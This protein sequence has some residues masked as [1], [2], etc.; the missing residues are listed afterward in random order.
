MNI[1]KIENPPL[2]LAFPLVLPAVSTSLDPQL[3]VFVCFGTVTVD[4]SHNICSEPF[5]I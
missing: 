3:I 5:H 1:K 4:L 2:S